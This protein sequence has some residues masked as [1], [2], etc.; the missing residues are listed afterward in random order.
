L[1]DYHPNGLLFE[2]VCGPEG[3]PLGYRA[4]ASKG[5]FRNPQLL[6]QPLKPGF[7]AGKNDR[8]HFQHHLRY[9]V[10]QVRN[11]QLHTASR[12]EAD[13]IMLSFQESI[14]ASKTDSLP[15]IVDLVKS[16]HRGR[17]AFVSGRKITGDINV[18]TGELSWVA[19]TSTLRDVADFPTPPVVL[20][21]G[22]Q[23]HQVTNAWPG[24]KQVARPFYC[25]SSWKKGWLLELRG[26]MN[27]DDEWNEGFKYCDEAQYVFWLPDEKFRNYFILSKLPCHFGSY[28]WDA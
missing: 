8:R 16:N 11:H 15:S 18:P 14:K 27:A 5:M 4:K 1:Q 7:Y 17:F 25:D 6:P 3:R 28:L 13:E 19:I 10:V 9:E 24:W 21:N 22:R 12:N 2:Y 23:C 26:T 20:I